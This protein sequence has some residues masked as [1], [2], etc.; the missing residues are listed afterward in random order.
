MPELEE[1]LKGYFNY[2][3]DLNEDYQRGLAKFYSNSTNA[4]RFESEKFQLKGTIS[5]FA[6]N[7]AVLHIPDNILIKKSEEKCLSPL[8]FVQSC[9][10]MYYGCYMSICC[11]LLKISPKHMIIYHPVDDHSK[12][13]LQYRPQIAQVFLKRRLDSL[14][15]IES[16]IVKRN[17]QIKELETFEF[18]K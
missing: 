15:A 13:V 10:Y 11:Y 16:S 18:Y 14:K 9:N 17:N 4:V 2:Q 12:Y 6:D 5:H 8:G 1:I 7:E 3:E